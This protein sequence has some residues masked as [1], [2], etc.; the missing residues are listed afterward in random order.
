MMAN[1]DYYAILMV[2]PKAERF[3]IEAA[4]RDALPSCGKIRYDYEGSKGGWL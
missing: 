3:V 1:K 2:H 4:Y